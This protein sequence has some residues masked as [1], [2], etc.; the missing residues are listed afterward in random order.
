MVSRYKGFSLLAL[1]ILIGLAACSGGKPDPIERIRKAGVLR[2][3]LDPSFPPFEYIA[4]N[5]VAGLDVDLGQEIGRRLGVKVQ[6][7][8]V[9]Y[10]GLYDSLTTNQADIIISALY[11][12]PA[13]TQDVAFSSP[14]FNAG[15]VLVVSHNSPIHSLSDLG[16]HKVAVVFGTEGHMEALRW[17][18]E[19]NPA[20]VLL[21]GETPEQVLG[22]LNNGSVEAAVVDNVA[23]QGILLTQPNLKVLDPPITDEIYV[24]AGR[25]DE[26]ALIIAIGHYLQQMQTDGTLNKLIA[27]W[28]ATSGH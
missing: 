28:M 17:E 26:E 21:S 15:E 5:Q 11:P 13:R 1:I 3:A 22:A 23:A 2:I 12:D 10:D 19:L 7:I 14:Y 6:F 18:K 16:G 24:V 27:Q 4:N 9:G 20:P 8:V 25:H